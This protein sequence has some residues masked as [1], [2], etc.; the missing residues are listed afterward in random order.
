MIEFLKNQ[1]R[2]APECEETGTFADAAIQMTPLQREF[3]NARE[4]GHDAYMRDYGQGRQINRR[5]MGFA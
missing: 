1:F 2:A 4:F 5:S 3:V